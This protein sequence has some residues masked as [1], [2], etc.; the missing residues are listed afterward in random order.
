M[1]TRQKGITYASK[2]LLIMSTYAKRP[3]SYFVENMQKKYGRLVPSLLT[4]PTVQDQ[5][6]RLEGHVEGRFPAACHAIGITLKCLLCNLC[7]AAR[8]PPLSCNAAARSVGQKNMITQERGSRTGGV[9]RRD[10]CRQGSGCKMFMS[11][12]KLECLRSYQPQNTGRHRRIMK[13][14]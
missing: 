9:G 4:P 13:T 14:S 7:Y 8:A 5:A 6:V 2:H 1:E 10:A 11:Y 3:P 12:E